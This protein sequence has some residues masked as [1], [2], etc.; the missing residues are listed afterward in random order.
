MP[1]FNTSHNTYDIG[2]SMLKKAM[3]L[4]AG[5]G[6]RLR[7]LT[8]KRPKPLVPI[9]DRPLLVHHLEQLAHLGVQEV[10]INLHHLPTQIQQHLGDG[11]N[12]GIKIIYS[13]EVPAVLGTGGGV[14]LVEDVFANEAL[15]LVIN[16]DIL[17]RVDLAQA[18]KHHQNTEAVATL[19]VRP[20]PR[21]PNV[22]S[23]D[24]DEQGR[25]KR[26][27]EMPPEPTL[28]KRMYTGMQILT[29]RIFDYLRDQPPP[30]SCILRTAYRRMLA[31]NLTV[32]SYAI[33]DAYWRDIGTPQSYLQA[34]W[35]LLQRRD[36][37]P[38]H[39]PAHLTLHPPVWIGEG[40]TLEEGVVLGPNVIL[41]AHSTVG[42]GSTLSHTVVW[43]QGQV[44]PGTQTEHAVVLDHEVHVFPPTS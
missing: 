41:G 39:V 40:V 29:P 11:K 25:I 42:A 27:P 4:A 22:G 24:V 13:H 43:P 2:D 20:H 1:G 19:L 12:W 21:D 28:Y 6:T 10:V 32:G 35:E 30:P 23:V 7:P 37:Q 33:G 16:G 17:H 3:I 9:L 38:L 31:D 8:L 26:V 5:L 15:F 18:I 14:A 34:N 44:P 36:P